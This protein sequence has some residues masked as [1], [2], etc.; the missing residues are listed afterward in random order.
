MNFELSSGGVYVPV[1][2]PAPP[3][4]IDLFAGCGGFSL[5]MEAGGIDVAAAV[6]L[7]TDAACTYAYNLGAAGGRFVFGSPEIEAAFRKRAKR[8]GVDIDE[9]DWYGANRRN[10][11]DLTGDG[12]RAVIVAD[13]RELAGKDILDAAGLRREDVSVVF[14][15]PPCQG[16]SKSGRQSPTDER[17]NLVLEFLRIAAEIDADMFCM[18]NVPP[19]ISGPRFRPLWKEFQR[20]SNE[21]GWDVVA[22]ILNAANYGVPQF[23]ERAFVLGYRPGGGAPSIPMPTTWMEGARVDGESWSLAPGA[24]APGPGASADEQLDMFD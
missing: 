4:G 18:E 8:I 2:P 1:T 14:G 3:I 10:G 17:N 21:A 24:S 13:V 5:G 9:P 11:W 16:L 12:A 15:G 7:N 6:E 22:T 23:R 20:R 19:L